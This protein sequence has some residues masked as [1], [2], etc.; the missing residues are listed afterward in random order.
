MAKCENDKRQN[1]FQYKAWGWG[2][3][4]NSVCVSLSH[5]HRKAKSQIKQFYYFSPLLH[6]FG[7]FI[8][9]YKIKKLKLFDKATLF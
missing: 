5:F 1:V 6:K 3:I 7:P 9:I 8:Y 4:D 2:Q